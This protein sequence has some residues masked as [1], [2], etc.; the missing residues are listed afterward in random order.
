MRISYTD[1]WNDIVAIA[2]ANSS[3]LIAIAGAFVFLPA[4]VAS[5]FT[6][7]FVNPGR[8]A[9]AAEIISAYSAYL[10]EN[11]L[12]R[13][14]LLLLS[15]LGQLLVYIVL[16][17]TRRPA[18]GEAFRVAGPLFVPFLLT[19]IVV[20]LMLAGGFVLF[21]VPMLYL[22]GRVTLS[23]A[24]FVAERR[25]NPVSAI[26]RSFALTR[27]QGWRIFFFVFLVFLV[28]FVIQ[29]AIQGTLG[30]ALG[31]IAEDSD[32]FGL[33]QLLLAALEALFASIY[34]LLALTMWVGLYRRLASAG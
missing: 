27:G 33:G 23:A 32:R 24:A 14:V 2:R 5:F 8:D 18:V 34:T 4:I 26:G 15:T 25:A 9:E 1:W 13:L 20:T 12:P 3:I 11:W 17:D 28:V 10:G 21:V 22:I 6:V 19:N 30:T 16:L 29:L 7:P 31:L